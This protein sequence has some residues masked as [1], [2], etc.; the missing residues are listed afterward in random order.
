MQ[1]QPL[2]CDDLSDVNIAL[3][4]IGFWTVCWSHISEIEMVIFSFL[5]E[6]YSAG[7]P[8]SKIIVAAIVRIPY[9]LNVFVHFIFKYL[10]RSEVQ[11]GL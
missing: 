2:R 8:I 4:S 9:A 1:F 7:L 11:T 10:T 6:K 5:I 3:N